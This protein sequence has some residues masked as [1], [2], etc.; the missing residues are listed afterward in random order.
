MNSTLWFSMEIQFYTLPP[1]KE[2]PRLIN[3]NFWKLGK[4]FLAS[5][6]QIKYDWIEL[7]QDSF[8]P[9][10]KKI[11]L[12]KRTSFFFFFFFLFFFGGGGGVFTF[13]EYALVVKRYK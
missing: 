9:I 5:I 13:K 6:V 3:F 2:T 10:F 8:S 11:K 12:K 1:R 7:P 4:F